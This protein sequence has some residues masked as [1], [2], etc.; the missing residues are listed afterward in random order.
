MKTALNHEPFWREEAPLE[1]LSTETPPRRVEVLIVGA[2]FTGLSCA[3]ALADGGREALVIDAQALGDGASGRNG[4]MIGW[5]H[6]AKL[7][8][9]SRRYGAEAALEILGEAKRSYDFTRGL[10]AE[11]GVDCRLRETGRY[12]AAASPARYESLAR[13]L[14]KIAP[15]VGFEAHMIPKSDQSAEITTG[16]YHGGAL[17][18]THAT[19]HPGLFH[20]GLLKA[21]RASGAA[22]M[23]GLAARRIKRDGAQ[24]RVEADRGEICAETLVIATNGYSE[25][26][27]AGLAH[28]ARRLLPLPSFIIAT[29]PLGAN[30]VRALMPGGRAYVDTRSVHSYFRAD[31]GGERIV[32]GGRASLQ[33]ISLDKAA[34]RLR[35]HMASVFPELWDVELT[36][37][38]KGRIAYTSD[39][40]PHLGRLEGGRLSGA[41]FA[42]GYCGSGVALAPYLG[43]RLGQKI[44]GGPE[45]A[46]A[47]DV[48]RFRPFLAGPARPWI[49]AATEAWHK[50]LERR[51]G[52]AQPRWRGPAR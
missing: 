7:G 10:I 30:K 51:E 29:T 13:D 16:A 33:D 46:S 15:K 21:A 42:A 9:L 14:A 37:A 19:L 40:I 2:G 35:A 36:H 1:A 18:P 50:L 45:A 17:F 43:W 5:G 48:A 23:G 11:L 6:R 52:V 34:P 38:W 28:L 41:Y 3:K 25:I 20:Q 4:G 27:S 22:A 47:L 12:L 44:L 8:A 32:W 31:P 39:V 24:W 26:Y 49:L